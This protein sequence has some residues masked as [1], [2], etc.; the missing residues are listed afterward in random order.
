MKPNNAAQFIN[1]QPRARAAWLTAVGCLTLLAATFA[2][3]ALAEARVIRV[4]AASI[5]KLPARQNYVVDLRQRNVVYD[6]D[7]TARTIDWNRVSVRTADGEAALMAYLREHSPKV[8]ATTPTRLVIGATSG[9][10]K[11]LKLQA[12]PNPGTEYKCD[13]DT[14]SCNCAGGK[15]CEFMLKADVCKDGYADC[16]T[17]KGVM[18]CQCASK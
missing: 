5:A 4:T 3:A 11:V 7:G 16:G 14:K 10:M 2:Y 8:A 15:D 17:T 1:R 12:T 6:L 9:I 13:A 18:N